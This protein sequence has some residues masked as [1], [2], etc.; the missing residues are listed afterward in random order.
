MI[1]SKFLKECVIYQPAAGGGFFP[2]DKEFIQ[3]L[4]QEHPSQFL[5]SNISI[6]MYR[7]QYTYKTNAGK[8]RKGNVNFLSELEEPFEIE[9]MAETK[10]Q[11]YLDEK[12]AV[13]VSIDDTQPMAMYNIPI[14]HEII[15]SNSTLI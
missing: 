3:S 11:N 7:L 14:S 9:V 1:F 13:L 2:A 15:A 8:Y 12:K 6:K 4:Q 10:L 5:E